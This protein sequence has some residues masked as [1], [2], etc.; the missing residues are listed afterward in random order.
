[1]VKTKAERMLSGKE[2]LES[3]CTTHSLVFLNTVPE[4]LISIAPEFL[5]SYYSVELRRLK[6]SCQLGRLTKVVA[7]AS[8]LL[9]VVKAASQRSDWKHEHGVAL[10]NEACDCITTGFVDTVNCATKPP[11]G[12]FALL[13]VYCRM[14]K[15]IFS[16]LA[17]QDQPAVLTWLA[18]FAQRSCTF[19]AEA[20]KTLSH[21][22]GVSPKE[23]GSLSG[24]ITFLA[25]GLLVG[26]CVPPEAFESS[27]AYEAEQHIQAAT[28]SIWT[29]VSDEARPW[30]AAMRRRQLD[31]V[32]VRCVLLLAR[33][34]YDLS[35][36]ILAKYNATATRPTR[37]YMALCCM[38]HWIIQYRS[39]ASA[40]G[41]AP[42]FADVYAAER[43]AVAVARFGSCSDAVTAML[44]ILG[45]SDLTR[46]EMLESL[47]TLARVAMLLGERAAVDAVS[48][49]LDS[50]CGE[51][52]RRAQ[53]GR[54]VATNPELFVA[55]AATADVN[56]EL[57]DAAQR[58]RTTDCA[59]FAEQA[60][61]SLFALRGVARNRQ[62]VPKYFAF[63]LE[64]LILRAMQCCRSERAAQRQYQ[65]Q[66]I[67]LEKETTEKLDG[68]RAWRRRLALR[69]SFLYGELDRLLLRVH[70]HLDTCAADCAATPGSR[71]CATEFEVMRRAIDRSGD[72]ERRHRILWNSCSRCFSGCAHWMDQITECCHEL[73]Q[74]LE[75]AEA[76]IADEE[77]SSSD[78][79]MF[80][81]NALHEAVSTFFKFA[82]PNGK[83]HAAANTYSERDVLQNEVSRLDGIRSAC[84]LFLHFCVKAPS[85]PL[86]QA[87]DGLLYEDAIAAIN[88]ETTEEEAL[89]RSRALSR[90]S[91]C[92]DAETE[93]ETDCAFFSSGST[94]VAG[95]VDSNP[96]ESA[97]S[98]T[99][100]QR[101]QAAETVLCTWQLESDDDEEGWTQ[102]TTHKKR[103]RTT[104]M[105]RPPPIDAQA[106]RA[107]VESLF[108]RKESFEEENGEGEKEKGEDE[109]EKG[110]GEEEKGEDKKE[111]GEGEEEKGEDEKENGEDK[112]ENGEGEEEK[113]EDEKENGEG[114]EEKGEGEE[115]NG[116]EEQLSLSAQVVVRH[117]FEEHY[118]RL[119]QDMHCIEAANV[120]MRAG[121]SRA[122]VTV[123]RQVNAV[124]PA[125][126]EATMSGS[127]VTDTCVIESDI[128][129]VILPFDPTTCLTTSRSSLPRECSSRI[130]LPVATD[131]AQKIA[132]QLRT[133]DWAGKIT[134]R[135]IT[136]LRQPLVSFSATIGGDAC[137]HVDISFAVP[138][139]HAVAMSDWLRKKLD[140]RPPVRPAVRAIK[141]LL[142]AAGLARNWGGGLSG[143][144]VSIMM[145]A[146]HDLLNDAV[147]P[148]HA[149]THAQLLMGF[150]ELFGFKFDS[151]EWGIGPTGFFAKQLTTA[152]NDLWIASPFDN[153]NIATG[154]YNYLVRVVPTLQF[155]FLY[156]QND[157][158]IKNCAQHLC[159]RRYTIC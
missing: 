85:P 111:N 24:S 118:F 151:R 107:N 11:D 29:G 126:L 5:E 71:V 19:V 30:P 12:C 46:T 140:N 144:C 48:K 23:L 96:R 1:M 115:E 100:P 138:G 148:T 109:K 134:V 34:D 63:F 139:N 135:Q 110:E 64:L 74:S 55:V 142:G 2:Y 65:T 18:A 149:L 112:K 87:T 157:P 60:L 120:S 102:L 124:L 35:R 58:T 61:K 15:R 59:H 127:L 125:T 49:Q 4:D 17:G 3:L 83:T 27:G 106:A 13:G 56:L 75:A 41:S 45:N 136:A 93:A 53:A 159:T 99:D 52:C 22:S 97:G 153:F 42:D 108:A 158:S 156:L 43:S 40:G 141:L 84:K 77:P 88:I 105:S 92:D 81:E 113:G 116:E 104:R 32:L 26:M 73:A 89:P 147:A 6:L 122:A 91:L 133:S 21:S 7:H 143:T 131:T 103:N 57:M 16:E 121:L 69:H 152:N 86:S 94:S 101:G 20:V 66:L 128:D 62:D 72:Q 50:R 36:M 154:A 150:C 146:V 28:A 51:I 39:L 132:S 82:L 8:A 80:R 129:M 47:R 9:T 98:S 25:K 67:L 31:I 54:A 33:C 90:D 37:V 70:A 95:S 114:E 78:Y 123:L 130:S 76:M 38:L 14:G 137:A 79:Y 44:V 10:L 155:V 68:E 117:A 119:H 145:C